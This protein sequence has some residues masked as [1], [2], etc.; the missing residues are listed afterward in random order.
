MFPQL[1]CPRNLCGCNPYKHLNNR[2]FPEPHERLTFREVGS[3][4]DYFPLLA[5]HGVLVK[6]FFL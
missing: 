5:C 3:K 2:V 6:A 4:G 1:L